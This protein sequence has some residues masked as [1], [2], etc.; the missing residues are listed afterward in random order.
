MSTDESLCEKFNINQTELELLK[1]RL[2]DN[3]N[4]VCGFTYHP[5]NTLIDRDLDLTKD[6]DFGH[7]HDGMPIVLVKGNPFLRALYADDIKEHDK[8]NAK[9]YEERKEQLHNDYWNKDDKQIKKSKS[10]TNF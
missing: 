1:S 6:P 4:E 10:T 8:R 5:P 2:R 7:T 3:L 9:K